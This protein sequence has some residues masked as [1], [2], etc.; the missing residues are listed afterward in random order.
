VRVS[1]RL[2]RNSLH[3][4]CSSPRFDEPVKS[5]PKRDWNPLQYR[6]CGAGPTDGRYISNKGHRNVWPV[7]SSTYSKLH[8]A[9]ELPGIK[10][11]ELGVEL[12]R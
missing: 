8:G 10:G 3:T 6:T 12:L 7:L 1:L 11:M 4:W 9:A 5:Q 2:S